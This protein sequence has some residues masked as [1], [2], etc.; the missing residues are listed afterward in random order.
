M[1]AI[2]PAL[3]ARLDSGSTTLCRCWRLDRADGASLGFT[4]HDA[5]LRF[6]G[7][8]FRADAALTGGA[9]EHA[10]GAAPDGGEVSGALRSDAITA[11][12]VAAG[13]YAGARVRCWLVDWREP[14]LR[15]MLFDG[16]I[17]E[18]THG[19]LGFRAELVGPAAALNRPLGRAYLSACDAVLGD[20]RCKV[21]LDA[22][23]FSAEVVALA[24]PGDGRVPVSGLETFADGWFEG[25]RALWL[26]GRAAG[27]AA[28]VASDVARGGQRVL[29]LSPAARSGEA[30]DRLRVTAG[31]DKRLGT[32]RDRFANLLNFR[33][34]PHMPGDDWVTSHP[35]V[36]GVHSGGSRRG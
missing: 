7:L 10:T 16:A 36:G 12:D 1:R 24:E 17:A 13:L 4:D 30:G 18:I 2:D 11:E 6:D 32:C 21:D 15:A 8:E 34:F 27:S 20:A 19:S 31:C 23:A 5:S 35:A 22:P 26:S 25:G 29:T 9:L 33:G 14:D 3:Q 28:T